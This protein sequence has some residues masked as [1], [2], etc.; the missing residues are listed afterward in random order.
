[1]QFTGAKFPENKKTGFI[2][3]QREFAQDVAFEPFAE[4]E[5]SAQGEKKFDYEMRL[6]PTFRGSEITKLVSGFADLYPESIAYIS[7]T[8]AQ[9]LEKTGDKLKLVG[10]KTEVEISPVLRDN[11]P[12]DV[13]VV[14]SAVLASKLDK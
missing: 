6:A 12:D 10:T 3:P 14:K 8:L 13:V 7:N 2:A 4:D 5:Q 1:M 11:F 9:S